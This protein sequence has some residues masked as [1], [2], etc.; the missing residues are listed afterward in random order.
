M[1]LRLRTKLTLVM[2]WLVFLVAAVLS[3]VFLAQLLQQVLQET[4]KN[5]KEL[6]HNVFLQVQ[7]ALTDA[8]DQ[9][10][11]PSSTLPE[12]IHDYVRHALEINEGLHAQLNAAIRSPL[13]YEV[14]I[15]DQDGLVLISSDEN[16]AGQY[17]PR[18]TPL[19]QLVQRGLLHQVKVLRGTSR[20]VRA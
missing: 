19:S 7:N 11:R 14:S 12:D 6:A 18:R 8:A 13:I 4:D 3:V 9:G 10:I 2:T 20:F 16:E 17:L 5:A 15:T 1:Q